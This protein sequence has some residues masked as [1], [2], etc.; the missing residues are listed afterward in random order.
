MS[1]DPYNDPSFWQEV[2][3]ESEARRAHPRVF[4]AEALESIFADAADQ[5]E[6]L[7]AWRRK[8]ARFPWWAEDA[9][10]CIDAVL[11]GDEPLDDIAAEARLPVGSQAVRDWLAARIT[12]L[13]VAFDEVVREQSSRPAGG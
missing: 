1:F 3:A 8:V 10:Y 5:E 2:Q 7:G 11:A 12:P 4:A 6:A 13:H 9:L